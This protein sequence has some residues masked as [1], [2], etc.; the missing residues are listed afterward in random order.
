[1]QLY[2]YYEK[3]ILL[4]EQYQRAVQSK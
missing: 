4:T 2:I 1:M 3:K